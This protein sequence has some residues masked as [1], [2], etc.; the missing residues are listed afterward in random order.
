MDN[1]VT[2]M[3]IFTA[4]PGREKELGVAIAGGIRFLQE[5]PACTSVEIATCVEKPER[6]V[7]SV[8]WTSLE[9]HVNGFRN[10]PLFGQWIGSIKGLFED[11]PDVFHYEVYSDDSRRPGI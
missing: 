1:M 6:Y 11:N 10:S 2:E 3:A 4:L 5:Y 9:E 8:G 7:V